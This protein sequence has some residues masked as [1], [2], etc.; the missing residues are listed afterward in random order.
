MLRVPP[1]ASGKIAPVANPA[2]NGGDQPSQ[3]VSQAHY[4]D[5][6]MVCMYC[7]HFDAGATTCKLGVNGGKV[8]SEGGCDLFED[9]G[10]GGEPDSDDSG[11]TMNAGDQPP[12]APAK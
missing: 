10:D 9:M 4:R 12:G 5:G 2:E 7:S 3:D 1:P 6:N 8:E 11:A